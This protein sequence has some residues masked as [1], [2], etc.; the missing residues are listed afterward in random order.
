MRLASFNLENL[1]DRAKALNLDSFAEGKVILDK[2]AKLNNLFENPQ[3]SAADKKAI[4]AGLKDLGVLKDDNGGKFVCLRQNRGKLLKRPTSGPVEVVAEGRGDWVGWLELTTEHVNE[5]ATQNTARVLRDVNADVIATIEVDNRV[6]VQRFNSQS[7]PFVSAASYPHVMVIDGNDERGIDVGLMSRFPIGTMRSHVD[8]GDNGSRIF[9]RDCAEYQV[10]LPGG[11]RL[12]LL[13]NHLKS[14]GFGTQQDSDARRLRQAQRVREIYDER[15]KSGLTHIAVVGDFNDFP[16]SA[17][18]APLL[19]NGS[20]LRDVSTH[21]KFESDGRPGTF[22]NGTATEKIDY[23]LLSP[24]LFGKVKR[25]AVFRKG[26]WGGKNGTLF[27]HFPE[28]TKAIHA[29]SDHAAIFADL[30]I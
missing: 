28:M 6:A 13:V 30:S 20:N 19:G 3:Y 23:I 12:L 11:D 18:L 7:L 24:E 10:L 15:R 4:L 2:F 21:P 27:P 25:A 17:A 14:K 9:S 8:D 5:I 29:A 16:T 1:F 26:V 22:G